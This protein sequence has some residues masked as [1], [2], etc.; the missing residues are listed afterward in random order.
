VA[1]LLTTQLVADT[2]NEIYGNTLVG[3]TTT[4]LYGADSMYNSI[5]FWKGIGI[6]KGLVTIKPD[7]DIYEFWH[8][9]VKD[10][11]PDEYE[12]KTTQKKDTSGPPTN[13]KQ[14]ILSIIF[15]QVGLKMSDYNHGFERG[16]YYAP[17]F[18]NTREFL[19]GEITKEYLIPSIKLKDDTDSVLNW[20]RL[21]KMSI[22]FLLTHI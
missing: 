15:K 3:L 2:W 1:S 5:P 13:V 6:S 8:H 9:W 10:N 18:E 19:R 17:R 4:S 7:D 22:D 12:S 11:M 20:W 16:V 21:Q 14:K